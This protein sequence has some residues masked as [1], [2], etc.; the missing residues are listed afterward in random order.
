[1]FNRL[2]HQLFSPLTWVLCHH[3]AKEYQKDTYN[4]DYPFEAYC[5]NFVSGLGTAS[6]YCDGSLRRNGFP[7]E[8]H[9]NFSEVLAVK[10]HYASLNKFSRA[11]L[12]IRNPA[13]TLEAFFNYENAGHVG[14]AAVSLCNEGK[15]LYI[16]NMRTLLA[17]CLM[18]IKLK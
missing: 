16:S 11:I 1:M 4:V 8:C 10:S 18:A 2:K 15:Y 5:V 9:G 7:F 13:H 17:S 3:T 6:V 14:T 12:V